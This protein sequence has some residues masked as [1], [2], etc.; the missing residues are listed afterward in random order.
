MASVDVAIRPATAED[1]SAVVRLLSTALGWDD[2]P[3]HRALFEWKHVHNPFGPSP[4]WVA[5]H[6]GEVVAVRLF[7]RWELTDA[8]GP[9]RVVRAVDT[10]TDPRWQRRG[11]FRRLT[12]TAL[13]AL[14]EEGVELVFNTPNNQSRPGYLSLGWEVVGRLPAGVRITSPR[15]IAAV[16]RA[17]TAAQRWSEATGA[18]LPAT[19]WLAGTD[20]EPL[21]AAVRPPDGLHTALSPAYLRWRYG[22]P[23]LGYR[24]LPDPGAHAALLFRVRR[25]GPA[26]ELVVG[27][28]LAPD[29]GA[30]QELVRRALRATGAD[31]AIAV[32]RDVRRGGMV[33][34]PRL[35]PILTARTVTASQIP[36][37]AAWRGLTLGDIELF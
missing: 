31:H 1:L 35:G 28:L 15:R 17:R 3:R 10:A 30:A 37:P 21:S 12:L 32:G 18:G 5:V 19:E 8:D 11:L 27:T 26:R 25:R 7:L 9:H 33:G 34:V 23:E 20:I 4:G 14:R 22:L 13:D 2:D 29:R 36:P 6:D 16:L 24:V